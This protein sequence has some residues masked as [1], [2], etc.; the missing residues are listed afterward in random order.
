MLVFI[1]LSFVCVSA[2]IVLQYDVMCHFFAV[3]GTNFI[4]SASAV[5][6]SHL[7]SCYYCFYSILALILVGNKAGLQIDVTYKFFWLW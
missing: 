2:C 4:A 1:S 3:Y 5:W 7:S 6:V